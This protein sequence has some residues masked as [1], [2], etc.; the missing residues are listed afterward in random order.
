MGD[1]ASRT[2]PVTQDDGSQVPTERAP[3]LAGAVLLRNLTEQCQAYLLHVAKRELSDD[4]RAKVGASDLVQESLLE[5]QRKIAQF[6]GTT[7]AEL[8]EWLRRILLHKAARVARD[9]RKTA[10]RNVERELSLDAPLEAGLPSRDL[11]DRGLTPSKCLMADEKIGALRQAIE[12]LRPL[13]RQVILLRTVEQRTFA[14]VGKVIQ[15]SEQ[16]AC[17]L[18]LRA[19]EALRAEMGTVDDSR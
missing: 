19:I 8:T 10:K 2:D 15:R 13:H 5:G 7:E 17:K 16:A 14:D 9:F 4:L 12:Q 11:S 3:I 1:T 18:W 6:R